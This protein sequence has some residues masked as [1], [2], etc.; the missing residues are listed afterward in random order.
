MS[1]FKETIAYR[2]PE[3]EAL[4]QSVVDFVKLAVLEVDQEGTQ[5]A[6]VREQDSKMFGIINSLPQLEIFL[7]TRINGNYQR[8]FEKIGEKFNQKREQEEQGFLDHPDAYVDFVRVWKAG[9]EWLGRSGNNLEISSRI[10]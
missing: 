8:T 4:Q 3:A 2:I 10:K 6:I 9:N 5:G 7:A 1:A